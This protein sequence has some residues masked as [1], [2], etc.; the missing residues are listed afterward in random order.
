M[1]DDDD[2]ASRPPAT[3]PYLVGY[4]KPPVEHQFKPGNRAAARRGRRPRTPNTPKAVIAKVMSE[5]VEVTSGGRVTKMSKSEAIVRRLVQRTMNGD[6]KALD[7]LIKFGFN[8][9]DH[10]PA[11]A[12]IKRDYGAEVRAKLDQMAERLAECKRLGIPES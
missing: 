6:D 11:S 4:R 2:Q 10:V 5:L 9:N 7:Q 8:L 12:E 3:D 1:S